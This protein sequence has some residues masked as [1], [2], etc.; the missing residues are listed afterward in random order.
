MDYNPENLLSSDMLGKKKKTKKNVIFDDLKN[1]VEYAKKHA[2]EMQA[3][4]QDKLEGLKK[5]I[6]IVI[7]KLYNEICNTAFNLDKYRI[8]IHGVSHPHY[9]NPMNLF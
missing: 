4:S 6:N 2:E 9:E 8:P 7:N 3:K 1:A 5:D